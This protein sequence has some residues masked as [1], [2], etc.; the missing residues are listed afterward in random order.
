LLRHATQGRHVAPRYATQ[1]YKTIRNKIIFLICYTTYQLLLR[2]VSL[3][4]ML[5]SRKSAETRA[6]PQNPKHKRKDIKGNIF[7]SQYL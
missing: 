2:S 1:I 7:F 3:F 5:R 4:A 6:N